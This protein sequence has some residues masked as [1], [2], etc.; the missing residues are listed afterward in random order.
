MIATWLAFRDA[1]LPVAPELFT[2]PGNTVFVADVKADGSEVFGKYLRCTLQ[3]DMP[4]ERPRPKIDEYVS[5]ADN[6]SLVLPK[7][8]PFELIIHPN[9]EWDLITLDLT[10]A[11]IPTKGHSHKLSSDNIS[12]AL[13]FDTNLSLIR[14]HLTRQGVVGRK[15][16]K[17]K[18]RST[19]LYRK[20]YLG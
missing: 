14:E 3:Q 15:P 1:G 17:S 4:R 18:W 20:Y 5:K 19:F 6:A 11:K 7:D 9:G 10:N 12:T 13:S 8:D 16:A 2:R